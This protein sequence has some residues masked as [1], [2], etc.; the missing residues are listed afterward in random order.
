M[1]LVYTIPI[2]VYASTSVGTSHK[3]TV[4]SHTM[5]DVYFYTCVT[6]KWQF[7]VAFLDAIALSSSFPKNPSPYGCI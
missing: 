1:S 2:Q 5:A 6:D 3:C 7:L 4:A